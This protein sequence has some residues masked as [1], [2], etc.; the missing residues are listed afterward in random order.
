M[1]RRLFLPRFRS[2]TISPVLTVVLGFG[3]AE[4]V[5]LYPAADS[6]ATMVGFELCHVCHGLSGIAGQVDLYAA[7]VNGAPIS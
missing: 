7:V 5:D 3:I 4:R 2:G 6:G 1:D